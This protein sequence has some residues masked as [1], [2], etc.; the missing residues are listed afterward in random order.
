MPRRAITFNRSDVRAAWQLMEK[1]GIEP[2]S[3]KFDAD[4]TFRIMT[5][6]HVEI[7][8]ADKTPS[9]SPSFWDKALDHAKT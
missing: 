3:V 6:K 1:M 9:S 8:E 2:V 4:G 5:R 7:T